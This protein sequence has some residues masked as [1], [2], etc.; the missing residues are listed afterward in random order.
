[1]IATDNGDGRVDTNDSETY[2]SGYLLLET[3][4]EKKQGVDGERRSCI[5][6]HLEFALWDCSA[7]DQ[8]RRV[9]FLRSQ[10]STLAKCR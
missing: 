4:G 3:V 2:G 5:S 9:K 10:R 8:R 7:S 6:R 1:M